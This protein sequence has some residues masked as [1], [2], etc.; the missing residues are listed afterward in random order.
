MAS[1]TV[2]EYMDRHK[3]AM[4]IEE[5]VNA[6]VRAKTDDPVLYIVSS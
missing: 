4:R 6:A 5:A 1:M 2:Q 3:L